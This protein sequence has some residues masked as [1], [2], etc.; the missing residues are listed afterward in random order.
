MSAPAAFQKLMSTILRH[1]PGVQ[2]YLDDIIVFGNS[3]ASHVSHPKTLLHKLQEAGLH[4]NDEKCKFHQEKPGHTISKE[5]L[6]PGNSHLEAIQNTPAPSDASTL[7]S[8]LGLT[9]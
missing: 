8:F 4:L 2:F 9:A 1:V 6:M 5:G 3:A 7:R